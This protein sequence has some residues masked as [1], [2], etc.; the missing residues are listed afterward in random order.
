MRKYHWYR[1]KHKS[2][3]DKQVGEHYGYKDEPTYEVIEKFDLRFIDKCTL[4]DL[5]D[6]YF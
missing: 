4:D 6:R 2:K 3:A 5:F 1:S